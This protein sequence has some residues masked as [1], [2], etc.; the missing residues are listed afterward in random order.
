MMIDGGVADASSQMGE[1]QEWMRQVPGID[2]ATAISN[3]ETLLDSHGALSPRRFFG[4]QGM[5]RQFQA[6]HND[7]SHVLIGIP[8]SRVSFNHVFNVARSSTPIDYCPQVITFI[9]EDR[10]DVVVFDTAPTGHTLKLLNL[11]KVTSS[12]LLRN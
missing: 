3:V 8:E 5:K 10:Y 9:E 1:F 7:L 2:E 11:P 4:V 12:D 6:F